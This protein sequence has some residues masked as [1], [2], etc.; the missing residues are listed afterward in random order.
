[1]GSRKF[2]GV[3]GWGVWGGAR[4]DSGPVWGQSQKD[5]LRREGGGGGRSRLP[6][7]PGSLGKDAGRGLVALGRADSVCPGQS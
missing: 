6:C 3:A 2:L 5:I 4:S 1:M 7:S